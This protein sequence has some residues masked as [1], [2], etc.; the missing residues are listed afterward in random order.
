MIRQYF[1]TIVFLLTGF[2]SFAQV[3]INSKYFVYLQ[4]EPAQPFYIRIN[5]QQLSANAS[6]YLI[7]PQLKDGDYKLIV[8]FPQEKFPQQTYNFTIDSK[9]KGYLI[10]DFGAEGW[11]LFDLQTM[12][13]QKPLSAAEARALASNNTAS[14]PAA[15][16][17]TVPEPTPAPT[18]E[19][20][21]DVSDFTRVLSKAA[22]DPG[23][24]EKPAPE[25][26]P[27]VEQKKEVV[28]QQPV[29][30]P[31]EKPVEEVVSSAPQSAKPVEQPEESVVVQQQPV[32]PAV[33]PPPV[34][35]NNL[36]RGQSG[37]MVQYQNVNESGQP[38][39]VT[40]FIPEPKNQPASQPVVTTAPVETHPEVAEEKTVKEDEPQRFQV[41]EKEPI[42]QPVQEEPAAVVKTN[43]S[44]K[45]VA[46]EDDF[47]KL[48]R[49][50]SQRDNDEGMISQA[51]TAFK[52][53]C[54][55]TAQ[56]KY[57]SSMFL[58]NAG[59]YN[60]FEAA[61]SF[62]ADPENFAT[63][64]SEIKDDYYLGKFDALAGQ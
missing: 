38:E 40:I 64:R 27:V 41:E 35:N 53:K 42:P 51:K 14:K 24:L 18:P 25:P 60:F 22:N 3:N 34:A 39:P 1:F 62:V 47:L 19:Q 46:N 61:R 59:K 57:L 50:M 45:R 9:D 44:C 17:V 32:T 28:V 8:G 43:S 16:A 23:L 48:R 10:K 15:P 58:S 4:T 26:E 30:Q 13:V 12:A 49:Q 63:L 36:S 29:P 6:G 7:L 52:N 33:Q 31:V 21:E 56:I 20:R 11:G 54:Y 5:G 55:S 2:V 37:V